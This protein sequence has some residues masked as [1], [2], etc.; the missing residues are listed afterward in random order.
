MCVVVRGSKLDELSE[1]RLG[2]R[3]AA[4]AEVGEP[5][6]LADRRL[7]RLAALRLLERDGRLGGP[8]VLEVGLPL[9][10]QL[11]RIAHA[12]LS[13]R[14]T[15]SRIAAATTDFGAF[16]TCLSPS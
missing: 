13:S 10:E 7:P 16:D 3:P 2:F 9:H 15:S 1:L 8:A 6:R 14:S 4:D 5:E 12:L 11:V